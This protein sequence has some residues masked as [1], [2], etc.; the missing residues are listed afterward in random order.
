MATN[1]PMI[2]VNERHQRALSTARERLEESERF[3]M[4]MGKV[5]ETLTALVADLEREGID[6]AV[7][8]GM[9]LNRHGYERE[10]VDV[11]VLVRPDGLD[12]FHDRLVGRGYRP[13]FDGARKTFKYTRTGTKIEFIT[14]GEYPGDGKPKPVVFPD[15]AGVYRV[16]DGARIIDLP[17]LVELKLASGMTNTGRLKDLGDVQELMRTLGLTES[18]ADT[19]DPYV[20]ETYLKLLAGVRGDDPYVEKP[21]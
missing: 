13:A 9:A 18:F 19:L 4:G 8:G 17:R 20:R 21:K 14:T 11:D 2:A 10:T 12:A 3:H 16:I 6:Y 5:R 15:P 1:G 7:I